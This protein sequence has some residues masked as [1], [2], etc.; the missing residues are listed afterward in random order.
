MGTAGGSNRA[1]R[2]LATAVVIGMI[3][4]ATAQTAP[5][6]VF[7]PDGPGPHPA[8]VFASGCDGFA[9]AL[10]P[11]VYDRA[12]E[13]LRAQGYVVVYADYLGR[14]GMR[15]CLSGRIYRREAGAEVVSA[16]A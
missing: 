5:Y 4:V 7:Q 8:V 14:R 2:G 3:N 9:P 11:K 16:A 6:R 13:R 1:V 10:A 15:T 12:A